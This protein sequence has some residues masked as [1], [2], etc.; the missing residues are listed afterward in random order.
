MNSN[1]NA[2][3][4]PKKLGKLRG[5]ALILFGFTIIILIF[6]IISGESEDATE[7]KEEKQQGKPEQVEKDS[8]TIEQE[9]RDSLLREV[10]IKY[11]NI[12]FTTSSCEIIENVNYIKSLVEQGAIVKEADTLKIVYV[13]TQLEEQKEYMSTTMQGVRKVAMKSGEN[14]Q[15]LEKAYNIDLKEINDKIKNCKEIKKVLVKN[16]K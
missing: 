16:L 9:K 6:G 12:S 3:A 13:L 14:I 11:N 7:K 15:R 8:L 4:N 10:N 1:E 5:C 2:K